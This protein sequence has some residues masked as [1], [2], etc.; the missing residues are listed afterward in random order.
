[1]IAIENVRLFDEVQART[2][3]GQSSA[4]HCDFRERWKA[5][6]HSVEL[7]TTEVDF[8]SSLTVEK[9]GQSQPC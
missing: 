2:P 5:A 1:V 7:M 4:D 8:C 6:R 9:P 3:P